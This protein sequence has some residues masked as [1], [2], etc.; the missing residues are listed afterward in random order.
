MQLILVRHSKTLQ[1]KSKSNLLW[2][3]SSEGIQ[4]ADALSQNQLIKN[5]E[6]LYTSDQTK[7]LQTTLLLAKDNYIPI[8]IFP[9]LTEATSITNGYFENYESRV[10]QWH[11]TKEDRINNGET[12]KE[13]LAR[14]NET[15]KN[16]VESSQSIYPC[17]GIVS[18]A[19]VL[20]LYTAQFEDRTSSEIHSHIRMPD[21][22]VL[23]WDEHR[24]IKRFGYD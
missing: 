5:I 23:D 1:E 11:N 8:K 3:L 17:I 24:L 2:Q 15:I 14:F 21:I 6:C 12:A 9:Q 19:N 18:H 10:T 4:L 22:A 20:S 16:I 7:A 13:A